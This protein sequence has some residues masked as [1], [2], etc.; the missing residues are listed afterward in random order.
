MALALKVLFPKGSQRLKKEKKRRER[1]MR[2]SVTASLMTTKRVLRIWEA[3]QWRL[4]LLKIKCVRLLQIASKL[5]MSLEGLKTTL[6]LLQRSAWS[7]LLLKTR[8]NK[9]KLPTISLGFQLGTDTNP[10]MNNLR[11]PIK[12]VLCHAK[13]HSTLLMLAT[14]ASHL[15]NTKT[16]SRRLCSRKPPAQSKSTLSDL[17]DNST[18]LSS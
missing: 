17:K 13:V 6:T 7:D 14:L 10:D 4:N 15:N 11:S 2:C 16:Y 18:Y 8:D 12:L 3:A 9:T 1:S 5:L